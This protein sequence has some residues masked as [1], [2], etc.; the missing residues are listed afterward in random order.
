[1]ECQSIEGGKYYNKFTLSSLQ[2]ARMYVYNFF[3]PSIQDVK[4][5]E[6]KKLAE[7]IKTLRRGSRMLL[8]KAQGIIAGSGTRCTA[9]AKALSITADLFEMDPQCMTKSNGENGIGMSNS[10]ALAIPIVNE[11]I[12]EE[13]VTWI[14]FE[15]HCKKNRKLNECKAGMADYLKQL[16]ETKEFLFTESDM[17]L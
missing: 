1:M 5:N 4:S 3:L 12:A 11:K 2:F 15:T 13:I 7:T 6:Q 17:W 10:V 16:I 14:K 8:N 9:S